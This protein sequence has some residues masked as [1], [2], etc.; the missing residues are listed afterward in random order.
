MDAERIVINKNLV[1]PQLLYKIHSPDHF[2]G[3]GKKAG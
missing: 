1:V 2:T 3:T